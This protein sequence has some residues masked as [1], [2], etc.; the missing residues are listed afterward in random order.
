MILL[1]F[2]IFVGP[3]LQQASLGRCT[4][5]STGPSFKEQGHVQASQTGLS[6]TSNWF[7]EKL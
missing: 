5:Q 2:W 4:C 1:D 6:L 7:W 3:G